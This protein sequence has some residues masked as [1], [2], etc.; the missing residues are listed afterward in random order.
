MKK[1]Y[2]WK[3][4]DYYHVPYFN[5]YISPQ[6]MLSM[7]IILEICSTAQIVRKSLSVKHLWICMTSSRRSYI[8][9]SLLCEI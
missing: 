8:N 6:E 9:M 1:Q 2:P 3:M 4:M 7:K 5:G